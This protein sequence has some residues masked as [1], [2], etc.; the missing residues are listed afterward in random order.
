MSWLSLRLRHE[1]ERRS[2]AP[3]SVVLIET[4]CWSGVRDLLV[5]C[6]P[7]DAT[8]PKIQLQSPKCVR[9]ATPQAVVVPEK[10]KIGSWWRRHDGDAIIVR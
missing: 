9:G 6:A 3:A 10:G 8:R 2:D 4:T 1:H 7:P 5:S